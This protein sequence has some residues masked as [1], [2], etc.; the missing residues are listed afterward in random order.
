MSPEELDKARVKE[1][2]RLWN[3]QTEEAKAL[4]RTPQPI[5]IAARLA[6]EGWTPPDPISPRVLAAREW[7]KG[8]SAFPVGHMEIEQISAGTYD[9][10]N[11]IIGF[12]AGFAAAVKLAEPLVEAL[13]TNFNRITHYRAHE[14]AKD[15]RQSIGDGE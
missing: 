9:H 11:G 3:E 13:G 6:R 14:L 15:Y 12:L 5:E 10:C 7:L 8:F 1:A 4:P 2:R